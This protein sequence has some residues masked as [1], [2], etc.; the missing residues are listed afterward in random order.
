MVIVI[1]VF[2]GLC[3]FYGFITLIKFSREMKEARENSKLAEKIHQEYRD[4]GGLT[5]PETSEIKDEKQR[6]KQWSL[7]VDL[8]QKMHEKYKDS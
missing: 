5:D 1:E 4:A 8:K 3:L 7:N 2:L 6:A